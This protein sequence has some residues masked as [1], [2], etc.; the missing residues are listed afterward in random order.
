MD[1]ASVPWEGA[2]MKIII[3]PSDNPNHVSGFQEGMPPYTYNEDGLPV[4]PEHKYFSSFHNLLEEI[5]NEQYIILFLGY[6]P[7]REV[8]NVSD[9]IIRDK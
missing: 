7:R 4:Y 8:K 9:T 2:G 6:K 1:R 3:T 5:T